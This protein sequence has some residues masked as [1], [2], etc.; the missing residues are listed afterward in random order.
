MVKGECERPSGRYYYGR[1][2]RRN[3]GETIEIFSESGIIE[4]VMEKLPPIEKIYEA[5]SAIADGRVTLGDGQ[6]K[7]TSSDGAKT[8]TVSWNESEYRSNDNATY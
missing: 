5:Y 7:V 6:A 4:T 1:K 3:M 8:Y 2:D